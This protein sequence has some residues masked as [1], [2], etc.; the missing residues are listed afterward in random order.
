MEENKAN[1]SS[2]HAFYMKLLLH[3]FKVASYLLKENR[4]GFI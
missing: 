4:A 1:Q 2:F 3:L